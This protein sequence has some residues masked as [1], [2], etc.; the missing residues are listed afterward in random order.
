MPN[1]IEIASLCAPELDAYARLTQ[2][3]LRARQEPKQGIFIAEGLKVIEHAL[4]AGCVPLSLLVERRHI[5]G[6]A[7]S[8]IARCGDVPVYTADSDVLASLTGFALTRGVLCAMRRPAPRSVC[9][10]CE[11]ARRLAVL[12]GLVDPT[13]VGAIF[14]NAAALGAGAFFRRR[15][16]LSDSARR[17]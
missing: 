8:V 1:I 15:M 2:S 17:I 5:A 13:N 10:V 6:K 14:R 9:D 3:Q 7:R 11:G 12:E 4:D 16:H